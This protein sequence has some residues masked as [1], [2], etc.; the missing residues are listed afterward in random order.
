[1]QW[2]YC[3]PISDSIL[4]LA[5]CSCLFCQMERKLRQRKWWRWAVV[6]L[7]LMLM[8]VVLY[9]TVGSRAGDHTELPNL[10]PFH[11]YRAVQAGANPEIY[12]SNFMN[13]ALFYPAGLM[14]AMLL[15]K[16]WYGWCRCLLVTILFCGVSTGI[17]Y[18]QYRYALGLCEIDDVIHNTA[19]VLAGGMASVLVPRI[20]RGLRKLACIGSGAIQD[21]Q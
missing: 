2:F 20:L 7:L 11:S 14:G 15:P 1:M 12:R 17:E 18:L 9:T 10:I 6:G 21:G 19:G 8:A 16:K 13:A 5:L 3:L 4:L